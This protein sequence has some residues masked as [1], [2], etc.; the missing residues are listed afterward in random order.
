MVEQ[1][2]GMGIKCH[3]VLP[4]LEINR[5]KALKEFEKEEFEMNISSGA[6]AKKSRTTKS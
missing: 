3:Y 5:R 1:L 6:V 4:K 2:E